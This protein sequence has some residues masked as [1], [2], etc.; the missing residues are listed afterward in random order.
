MKLKLKTNFQSIQEPQPTL[1]QELQNTF[2]ASC[3]VKTTTI[4]KKGRQFY[5]IGIENG[6]ELLVPKYFLFERARHA[7]KDEGVQDG[8]DKGLSPEGTHDTTLAGCGRCTRLWHPQIWCTETWLLKSGYPLIYMKS[9]TLCWA[10]GGI[11]LAPREVSPRDHGL[12]V[13]TSEGRS[14]G[15]WAVSGICYIKDMPIWPPWTRQDHKRDM[16]IRVKDVAVPWMQLWKDIKNW[17]AIQVARPVA[18][19]DDSV[20]PVGFTLQ[21]QAQIPVEPDQND[22]ASVS[23]VGF[24]TLQTEAQ[25]PTEADQKKKTEVS[26]R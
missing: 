18:L 19:A 17:R 13:L 6:G 1:V 21:T 2:G 24:I 26:R 16:T 5:S 20:S 23:P 3:T 22:D 14:D 4:K 9:Q 11:L 12:F 10:M 8:F 15:E 25:I 7:E